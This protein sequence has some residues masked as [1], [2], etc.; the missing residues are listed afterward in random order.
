MKTFLSPTRMSQV[1][2]GKSC[3]NRDKKKTVFY[4]HPEGRLEELQCL[5]GSVFLTE[6]IHHHTAE[7]RNPFFK[8]LKN[9]YVYMYIFT[10]FLFITLLN[11]ITIKTYLGST[12]YLHGIEEPVAADSQ[13]VA[14]RVRVHP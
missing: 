8:E 14:S 9:I 2:S 7:T 11:S 12:I 6:R 4:L 10:L 13:Q 5:C 3:I 1:C